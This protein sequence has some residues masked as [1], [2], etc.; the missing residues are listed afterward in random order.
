MRSTL[1]M[2]PYLQIDKVGYR[3]VHDAVYNHPEKMKILLEAGADPEPII[4]G[5]HTPLM[6]SVLCDYSPLTTK[7]LL[8]VSKL[9][10]D[11]GNIQLQVSREFLSHRPKKY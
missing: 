7:I 10:L 9:L 1:V 8:E 4:D 11:V 3:L 2:L 6:C 5:I